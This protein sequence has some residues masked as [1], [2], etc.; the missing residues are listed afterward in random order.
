MKY[1][2]FLLATIASVLVADNANASLAFLRAAQEQKKVE[3]IQKA[4]TGEM[5]EK[6]ALEEAQKYRLG[7][8]RDQLTPKD[9]TEFFEQTA[10]MEYDALLIAA[11]NL[12]QDGGTFKAEIARVIDPI[13]LETLSEWL[14]NWREAAFGGVLNDTLNH[15]KK[16]SRMIKA[17]EARDAFVHL[18]GHALT[19]KAVFDY[20]DAHDDVTL[21]G[22]YAAHIG[23]IAHRGVNITDIIVDDVVD[24]GRA[25]DVA[26]QSAKVAPE[27]AYWTGLNRGFTLNEANTIA[28]RVI[29]NGEAEAVALQRVVQAQG[30]FNAL[31]P[32][33]VAQRVLAGRTLDQAHR[34]LTVA[35]TKLNLAARFANVDEGI[36]NAVSE[37]MYDGGVTENAALR[38][39][40]QGLEDTG[41]KH[42]N[43]IPNLADA[44]LAGIGGTSLEDAAFALE[45]AFVEGTLAFGNL[46]YLHN[47]NGLVLICMNSDTIDQGIRMFC[48]TIVEEE[49][50]AAFENHLKALNGRNFGI[51]PLVLDDEKTAFYRAHV[52][53]RLDIDHNNLGT[54]KD[55]IATALAAANTPTAEITPQVIF[56]ALVAE[57]AVTYGGG[58][59]GFGRAV[60]VQLLGDNQLNLIAARRLVNIDLKAEE[61]RVA[62]GHL[63]LEERMVL[64]T[65]FIDQGRGN[66]DEASMRLALATLPNVNALG[67]N[68]LLDFQNAVLGGRTLE[69]ALAGNIVAVRTAIS[70]FEEG[71]LAHLGDD[72]LDMLTQKFLELGYDIPDISLGRLRESL[73]A[74]F[75]LTIIENLREQGNFW[76]RI[77]NENDPKGLVAAL[78]VPQKRRYDISL[79]EKEIET[80]KA[81]LNPAMK[82]RIAT[83]FVDENRGVVG[84]VSLRA[85]LVHLMEPLAFNVY[86]RDFFISQVLDYNAD[87]MGLLDTL[88]EKLLWDASLP[89]LATYEQ[90]DT[91]LAYV[92][93]EFNTD[94][95]KLK[96]A[97]MLHEERLHLDG[98][99]AKKINA[100][101]QLCAVM[102]DG[103]VD[104]TAITDRDLDIARTARENIYEHRR[105]LIEEA[106]KDQAK[107][108]ERRLEGE[109]GLL[110]VPQPSQDMQDV[111]L[112]VTSLDALKT[113]LPGGQAKHPIGLTFEAALE[114]W[115][116][117]HKL[118]LDNA[119]YGEIRTAHHNALAI[120]IANGEDIVFNQNWNAGRLADGNVDLKQERIDALL[121]LQ[122]LDHAKRNNALKLNYVNFTMEDNLSYML[123]PNLPQ[124]ATGFGSDYRQLQ[125]SLKNFLNRY[126]DDFGVRTQNKDDLDS[127]FNRFAGGNDN[128]SG[129]IYALLTRVPGNLVDPG[130]VRPTP[131]G[132]D[133]LPGFDNVAWQAAL[134]EQTYL[135][136][137]DVIGC[138]IGCDTGANR[139]LE[140]V[141]SGRAVHMGLD[142]P[143]L[144]ILQKVAKV[145]LGLKEARIT[146]LGS[147]YDYEETIVQTTQVATQRMKAI[148]S[149][150]GTYTETP[151][152][153]MGG[154]GQAQNQPEQVIRNLFVANQ[155]NR[156]RNAI[157]YNQVGYGVEVG[158]PVAPHLTVKRYLEAVHA[159]LDEGD[160][161][162][163]RNCIPEALMDYRLRELTQLDAEYEPHP[164]PSAFF[165]AQGRSTLSLTALF[166]DYIGEITILPAVK[167][168]LFTRVT[169]LE[170]LQRAED[171]EDD[172]NPTTHAYA[173]HY[174]GRTLLDLIDDF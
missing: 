108:E 84:N 41:L 163:I 4:Q 2:R 117:R 38:A 116:L 22:A 89:L 33:Q 105:F 113:A 16:I 134:D 165:D 28:D 88:R 87:L 97:Q 102:R 130:I 29:N 64:A 166:M 9:W 141:L 32:L 47:D 164:S 125:T 152:A 6:V 131:L 19:S 39:V 69:N 7:D 147:Q 59:A 135:L 73:Y 44:M 158:T 93:D 85:A 160:F 156:V 11:D 68:E 58:N 10:E 145:K 30:R 118:D 129:K 101:L 45:K 95:L 144:D 170:A 173:R 36:R 133:D 13:A 67:M 80:F 91:L 24:N 34:D 149:L 23:A 51:N 96:F 26:L 5:D 78:T 123:A 48:S 86:E 66:V 77:I 127:A 100:T 70:E 172:F 169:D 56:N 15:R 49:L 168:A 31:N 75:D 54:L 148:F 162:M 8:I 140:L 92:P 106:Q 114:A 50:A 83:D 155:P 81:G 111:N 72:E 94:E 128:W 17:V 71:V 150:P 21:K 60:A 76:G 74:L 107:I 3:I 122:G 146:E 126:V 115:K 139:K 174:G 40:L 1:D 20:M 52:R 132:E 25:Y 112:F 63:P 55:R 103:G 161:L 104:L 143:E 18:V 53:G 57:N 121:Q 159:T 109:F 99:V 153:Q 82:K 90:V 61:I 37:R 157:N 120:Q 35:A 110:N 136:I 142:L 98:D 137:Q 154:P 27:A 43:S 171:D 42:T 12:S 79:K 65:D 167:A 124:V 46:H 14:E 151:Y 62:Y 138:N 119:K